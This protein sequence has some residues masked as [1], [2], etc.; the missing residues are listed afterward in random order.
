M[1][2]S[3]AGVVARDVDVAGMLA[4]PTL[5]VG[6]NLNTARLYT[7]LDVPAPL[8]GQ[9]E[10]AIRSA[11]ASAAAASQDVAVTQLEYA[12]RRRLRGSTSGLPITRRPQLTKPQIATSRRS[13]WSNHASRKVP[14][15]G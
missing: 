6:S 10:A 5:T 11:R 1:A 8:F 4:N 9:R 13:V 7:V 15:H 14:P 2:I 3:R 12:T